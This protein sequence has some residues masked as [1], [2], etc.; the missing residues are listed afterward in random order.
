[1]TAQISY[2]VLEVK[3]VE[4]AVQ[5]YG[6]VFSWT[7]SSPRPSG[8]RR[9]WDT[10]PWGGLSQLP[11]GEEP[12]SRTVIEIVPDDIREAARLIVEN[13]GEALPI[14][15]PFG[16]VMACT[17]DQGTRFALFV[18]GDDSE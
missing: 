15:S 4:R 5:F 16:E 12:S 9:I 8:G 2:W 3:D 10:D 18:P 13:G 1:M 17:D 11:P 7:F 14:T 6:K